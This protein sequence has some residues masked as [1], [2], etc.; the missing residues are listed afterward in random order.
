MPSRQ[1]LHQ[2]KM[3]AQGRCMICGW[4]GASLCIIHFHHNKMRNPNTIVG[5]L[6]Q[7]LLSMIEMGFEDVAYKLT[8]KLVREC[9]RVGVDF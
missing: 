4:P 5:R 7:D 1:R 3:K 2:L 8:V 9:P 6:H